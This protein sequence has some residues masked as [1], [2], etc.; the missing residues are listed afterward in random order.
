MIGNK[1]N[2]YDY[3]KESRIFIQTSLWEDP[4]FVLLEAGYS[5]KIVLSSNCPNGPIEILDNGNIVILDN[6]NNSQDIYGTEYPTTRALEIEVIEGNNSCEATIL[7][8]YTLPENLFGFASGNVQ[9]L[10][11]G[12]YYYFIN[13]INI[14]IAKYPFPK[15]IYKEEYFR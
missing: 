5:N 10:E 1:K 8:E 13:A 2:I 4:G 14:C 12:N 7:W 15:R 9:K 6:G 3:L 11:N